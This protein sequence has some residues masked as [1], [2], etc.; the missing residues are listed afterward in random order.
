MSAKERIGAMGATREQRRAMG[1]VAMGRVERDADGFTV[2][3]TATPPE[4]FRVWEDPHAGRRCTCDA[5]GRAFRAGLDY[6]CEHIEAVVIASEGPEDEEDPAGDR[7]RQV[8]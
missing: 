4:P 1:I 3:S 7:V 6:A 8:M 2:Y 5:F